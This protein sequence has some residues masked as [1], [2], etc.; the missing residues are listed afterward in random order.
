MRTRTVTTWP[1]TNGPFP[2]VF[3]NR[4]LRRMVLVFAAALAG[5]VIGGVAGFV[6]GAGVFAVFG[7]LSHRF[8]PPGERVTLHERHMRRNRRYRTRYEATVQERAR[9]ASGYGRSR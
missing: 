1:G 2:G 8:E 5:Y 3:G 7:L 4:T 9:R 6:I